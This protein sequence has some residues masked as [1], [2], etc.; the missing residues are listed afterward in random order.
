MVDTV[1]DLLNKTNSLNPVPFWSA[2]TALYAIYVKIFGVSL[3]M[4]CFLF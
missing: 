4:L 2:S 1:I 3:T